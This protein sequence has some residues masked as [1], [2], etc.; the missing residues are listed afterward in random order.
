VRL[1]TIGRAFHWMDKPATL[2]AL[3]GLIEPGGAVALFGER[4][5]DVPEN[6]WHA[7]FQ[8][9]ID[10]YASDDPAKKKTKTQPENDAIFLRSPFDHIERIAVLERRVTPLEHI[11]DRALSFGAAWDG[12]PGSR[13]QDLADEVRTVVRK[14][15]DADGNVHEVIE[16][17]AHIGLRAKDLKA[18]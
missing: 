7:G 9:L 18:V 2:T 3:D 11:V 10:G 17:H 15:A 16:G 6:A 5:P 13:E 4:Y 12:R 14:F 1:V 8:A